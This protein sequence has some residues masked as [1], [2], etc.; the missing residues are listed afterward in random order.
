MWHK[1]KTQ[2][3]TKKCKKGVASA[4]E[5]IKKELEYELEMPLH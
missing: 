4:P 1:T 5:K 3:G 2:R